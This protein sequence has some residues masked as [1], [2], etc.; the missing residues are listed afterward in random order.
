MRRRK[1]FYNNNHIVL[2]LESGHL[3][4]KKP[5]MLSDKEKTTMPSDKSVVHKRE[6]KFPSLNV[7]LTDQRIETVGSSFYYVAEGKP[8]KKCVSSASKQTFRIKATVTTTREEA[9]RAMAE[10]RVLCRLPEHPNILTMI[11]SG[12]SVFDQSIGQDKEEDTGP[13]EEHQVYCLL[14]NGFP[15]RSLRDIIEKHQRKVKKCDRLSIGMSQGPQ[16]SG[17]MDIETVMGIFRQMALA[18]SVLHGPMRPNCAEG[19]KAQG[20]IIH[21]DLRPDHFCVYKKT[22]N[23]VMTG[24]KYIV[25]LIGAGCAVDS[26]MSLDS[27]P[28]RKRALCL[29]KS[30]TL[31]MYRAPEMVD[32]LL[33]DELTHK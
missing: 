20:K 5:T 27:I 1:S 33:A 29:I 10:I 26:S 18:V 23:E 16:T 12:C 3:G 30:T 28:A 13:L 31:Q 24:C 11:D 22:S 2:Y 25:K 6:L 32:I 4:Q 8:P 15:S 14:F 19:S 17:W 9:G 7:T 21:M